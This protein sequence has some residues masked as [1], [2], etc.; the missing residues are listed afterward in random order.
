MTKDKNFEQTQDGDK[1]AFDAMLRLMVPPAE[2]QEAKGTS[3]E[4]PSECCAESRTPQ[5]T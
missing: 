4:E 5:D 1:D 2:V 3:D